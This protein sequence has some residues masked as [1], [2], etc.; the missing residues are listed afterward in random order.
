[1]RCL[2]IHQPWAWAILSGGKRVEN[3]TWPTNHRGPLLIHA[4]K[5]RANFEDQDRDDWRGRYGV[6]LPEWSTLATGA[7]LGVANLASC[8]RADG[9][10]ASDV[11]RQWLDSHPFTEGPWCW[12]LKN[13]RAFAEPIPYRG[14]QGLFNV[15]D[16]VFAAALDASMK[17]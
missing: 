13:V 17:C 9:E 7:I 6:E 8:V 10:G 5:S 1:M 3:R 15:P 12:I 14:M 2:S 16:D 11:Q 4:S